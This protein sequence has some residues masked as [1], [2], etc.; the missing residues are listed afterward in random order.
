MAPHFC[1]YV[2]DDDDSVRKALSRLL[3]AS[4]HDVKPYASPERF[5]AEF[6]RGSHGCLI[7][8]MTMPKMTGL[9][10]Q[11]RMREMGLALPIIGMSGSDDN[12]ARERA[13]DLGASFFLQKPIDDQALLDAISWVIGALKHA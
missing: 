2:V 7:L 6:P 10:T 8:D 4:G 12:G 11:A 3:L 1:V 5:L 9:Q 13:R